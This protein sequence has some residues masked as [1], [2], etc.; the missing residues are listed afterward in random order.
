MTPIRRVN[1]REGRDGSRRPREEARLLPRGARL[2]STRAE[3][4]A[5]PSGSSP[6][7]PP[8]IRCSPDHRMLR[9]TRR[10][11]EGTTSPAPRLGPSPFGRT[12]PAMAPL[13]GS[14]AHCMTRCAT[15]PRCRTASTSLASP[16]TMSSER[17]PWARCS[18]SPAP[19]PL[20]SSRN[21]RRSSS[22]DDFRRLNLRNDPSTHLV[23]LPAL[24]RGRTVLTAPEGR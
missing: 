10:H 5:D 19:S 18:D 14:S 24:G 22:G 16:F 9:G 21:C 13:D 20:R 4:R 1:P 2:S 6:P 7:W 12:S 3:R 15:P 8:V 17:R 11:P 23:A